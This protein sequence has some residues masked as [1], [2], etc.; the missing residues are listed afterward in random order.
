[1]QILLLYTYDLEYVDELMEELEKHILNNTKPALDD[2]SVPTLSSQGQ[3]LSKQTMMEQQL[4]RGLKT[5]PLY[6]PEHKD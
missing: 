6:L 3:Q 4:S 5:K 1:M 2:R